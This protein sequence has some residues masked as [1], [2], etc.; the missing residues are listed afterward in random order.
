MSLYF[1][2]FSA[3]KR[4][5]SVRN[6][7]IYT[8]GSAISTT[9]MWMQRLAIGWLTWDLTESGTWLGIVAVAE[10]IAVLLVTPVGGVIAD[11]VDR[12]M[13]SILAQ[14]FACFIACVFSSLIWLGSITPELVILLVFLG[15]I[16]GALNQA[17]RI[18]LVT[19]MVPR[20]LMSTAIATTSVIFNMSRVAGP[21]VA[22]LLIAN[23]GIVWVFVINAVSY[24]IF[25]V[26][27][28]RLDMP[29]PARVKLPHQHFLADFFEG[30][31]YTFTSRALT[32]MIFLTAI[33]ALFSRPITE[34]LPGFIGSV[35]SGGPGQLATLTS[36]L[37][38][39]AIA[40]GLW[41]AQRG[42]LRGLTTVVFSAVAVNGLA[43]FIFSGTDLFIVAMAALLVSG[44]V[45]GCSGTGTQTL[46]QATTEDR[47][48]GRVISLWLV[49]GW[50]GP[51]L[52]A[53]A[54]GVLA[55]TLSFGT[56]L[57]I[58]GLITAA[59]TL[60]VMPQRRATQSLM[61]QTARAKSAVGT[62]S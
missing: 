37:G 12:R 40:A 14:S 52:G 47:M 62:G 4:A 21:A 53:L 1:Y 59:A 25:L 32:V 19:N 26:S 51:A 5:F 8:V 29:R 34:L 13:I 17:A 39:G 10:A 2:N 30:C 22:G 24:L 33:N 46:L 45:Q 49:I 28:L 56:P 60:W 38:I 6:F 48:R 54:M 61:E 20:E 43:I 27:L 58:G 55:E 50:G 16:A 41:L 3:V 44:F 11:R 23:V 7:A 36:C 9:G 42:T 31:R 57:M 15:G 35:F 18:T